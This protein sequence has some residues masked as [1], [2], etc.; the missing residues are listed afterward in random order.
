MVQRAPP[1]ACRVASAGVRTACA[2]SLPPRAHALMYTGEL[3]SLLTRRCGAGAGSPAGAPLVEEPPSGLRITCAPSPGA[4][5]A[6]P[7]QLSRRGGRAPQYGG[8]RT[9]PS[10]S[11]S[12][13]PA[14]E[15]LAL[16][17]W[18]GRFLACP[19]GTPPQRR[20][21]SSGRHYDAVACWSRR[22]SVPTSCWR[23]P[24]RVPANR[25]IRRW[26][27]PC[28]TASVRLVQVCNGV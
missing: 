24:V 27:A 28:L 21:G 26:T 12:G 6:L 16:S 10:A 20:A 8:G 15:L 14:R 2:S 18:R 11:T 9:P 17:P 7:G 5:G 22:E 23:V 1:R 3:R 13:A 4:G 19:V 25:Q